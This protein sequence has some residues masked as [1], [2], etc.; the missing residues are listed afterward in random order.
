MF[1]Q[2]VLVRQIVRS[3]T[4]PAYIRV[5]CTRWIF[6]CYNEAQLP[7]TNW[8]DWEN[9]KLPSFIYFFPRFLGGTFFLLL[10]VKSYSV[11]DEPLF[12]LCPRVSLT[13]RPNWLGNI[14][15]PLADLLFSLSLSCLLPRLQLTLC[16]PVGLD[17]NVIYNSRYFT[18][19]YIRAMFL[20]LKNWEKERRKKVGF[21]FKLFPPFTTRHLI[22]FH[23]TFW[24]S[25]TP[26]I[27]RWAELLWF[28]FMLLLLS[29][30]LKFFGFFSLVVLVV[31]D[32]LSPALKAHRVKQKIT[33]RP[34]S[35]FLT[36]L[37]SDIFFSLLFFGIMLCGIDMS[38]F[39]LDF[40]S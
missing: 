33:I 25:N 19:V 18:G 39:S 7:V 29:V 30:L 6:I 20:L 22:K 37:F 5:Y 38:G 26:T 17:T 40:Q 27:S 28:F 34:F 3:R 23:I 14:H 15:W 8:L 32:G 36:S 16:T 11:L 9:K 2:V 13:K 4:R 35:F 24:S 1:A 10:T 12:S 31:G 21:F